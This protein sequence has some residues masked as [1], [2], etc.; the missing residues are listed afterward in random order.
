MKI[1]FPRKQLVGKVSSELNKLENKTDDQVLSSAHNES[2]TDSEKE[3]IE[4]DNILLVRDPKDID[5]QINNMLGEDDTTT[6]T[7]T[8]TYRPIYME[9]IEDVDTTNL[10]LAERLKI[11][12]KRRMMDKM[13]KLEL[14]I[15][16]GLFKRE[17]T[18]SNEGPN[19]NAA[20]GGDLG[21]D[22]KKVLTGAAA[23]AAVLSGSG[24][25]TFENSE[26]GSEEEASLAVQPQEE[27]ENEV[28][29]SSTES[30][31]P[32]EIQSSEEPKQ[33]DVIS[34]KLIIENEKESSD[35]SEP[36]L[37]AALSS[38]SDSVQENV[39]K[40]E[41][42]SEDKSDQ[43]PLPH[44]ESET[45]SA[46]EKIEDGTVLGSSLTAV[47]NNEDTLAEAAIET[48][49]GEDA[50]QAEAN[51][52]ENKGI[53]SWNSFQFLLCCVLNE[54]FYLIFFYFHVI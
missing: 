1:L 45:N 16:R 32:Q 15:Q 18:Q 3:F 11:A 4:V 43:L 33:D 37:G 28:Q 26:N 42:P 10:T 39:T 14:S 12:A 6:T 49:N 8:E 41:A 31:V 24:D 35:V 46:N 34:V 19:A 48:T 21:T 9:P 52:S 2:D 5:D 51:N 54:K 29:T 7:T 13:A 40:N 50:T 17:N 38:S 53:T 30:A 44:N 23:E 20:E 47:N 22:L 27:T 36:N 25:S